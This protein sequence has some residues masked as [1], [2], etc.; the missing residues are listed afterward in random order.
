MSPN[1]VP[2]GSGAQGIITINPI[3]GYISPTGTP[4]VTL[5]CSSIT[6]LVTIPP[7]CSFNPAVVPVNGVPVT[8]TITISTFGPVTT[9]ALVH[10]RGFYALWLP[11]PLLALTGMGAAV[12]GKRSRKAWGLL[13][14]FVISGALFLMPACANTTTS[15]TTP[16]GITPANSYSFVVSG[17]DSDGVISSNGG[18]TTTNP[19]VTLTV[20]KPAN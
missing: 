5:S 9:G 13:G 1:S 12:G 10:P 7:V 20:T 6:P 15:T 11:L 18:L 17:V 3:N 2:A 19:T 16:N 4:G 8:A 14:L